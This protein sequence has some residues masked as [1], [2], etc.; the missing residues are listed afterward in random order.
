M[1]DQSQ[2]KNVL[3]SRTIWG[4][5]VMALPVVLELVMGVEISPEEATG[6]QAYASAII[7]GV[8]GVLAAWGRLAANKPV[9]VK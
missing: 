2:T 5:I 9:S 6:I 4:V 7:T 1:T 8:G 3:E